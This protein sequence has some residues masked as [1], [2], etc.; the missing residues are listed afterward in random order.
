M[1][2]RQRRQIQLQQGQVDA[3]GEDGAGLGAAP[4]AVALLHLDDAGELLLPVLAPGDLVRLLGAGEQLVVAL[5]AEELDALAIVI[6][7]VFVVHAEP[8][9][10]W[11]SSTGAWRLTNS[12]HFLTR[13]LLYSPELKPQAMAAQVRAGRPPPPAPWAR[14]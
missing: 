4:A 13:G 9:G 3:G 14:L 5:V 8:A 2:D 11:F 1:V 6:V 12:N 7:G 10:P